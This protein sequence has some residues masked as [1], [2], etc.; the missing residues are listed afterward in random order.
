MAAKNPSTDTAA[1][2]AGRPVATASLLILLAVLIAA[3]RFHTYGEPLERDITLYAVIAHEMLSGREL[4]SDLWDHKPP[5]VF[6]AYAAAEA[7]A[8]YGRA[9]IFLLNVAASAA[10]LAGI[11][12]ISRRMS[13]PAPAVVAAILWTF[14]SGDLHLEANQPNTEVFLNALLVWGVALMVKEPGRRAAVF[15]AAALFGAASLF[16]HVAVFPAALIAFAS[17]SGSRGR[18]RFAPLLTIGT[19]GF[20]MWAGVFAY[21]AGTGRGGDFYRAVIETNV[22]Y[23]GSAVSAPR[24]VMMIA[25]AAAAFA[26]I[27]RATALDRQQAVF[28]AYCAGTLLAVAV[29]PRFFPHYFQLWLPPAAI[30]AGHIASRLRHTRWGSGAVA[31]SLVLVCAFEARH[32][33]LP[34]ERWSEIKYGPIFIAAANAAPDAA[35]RA[36]PGSLYVWGS[37]PAFYFIAEKSPPAGVILHY[38]LMQ[39]PQAEELTRRTVRDLEKARPELIV[40]NEEVRMDHDV[41]RWILRRYDI[42]AVAAPAPFR[43][44]ARRSEMGVEAGRQPAK[45]QPA[46][47]QSAGRAD[48]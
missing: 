42:L 14:V 17:V 25:L 10:S 21:F 44:L 30:A 38:P 43:F 47:D 33:L 1:A 13:G 18:G 29:Q 19:A 39:G 11:W 37:E 4:Y 31:V 7:V 3:M 48:R 15:A 32:Y 20:L 22:F 24:A 2:G 28:T 6:V 41:P 45:N 35:R 46:D 27:A 40:L 23:A 9:A 12:L 8:G 5:A 26:L 34:A 36:G 16:K